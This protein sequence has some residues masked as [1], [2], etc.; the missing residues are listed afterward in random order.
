MQNTPD[1]KMRVARAV[2]AAGLALAAAGGIQ[3]VA[4][5]AVTRPS[6]LAYRGLGTW[7]DI[8]DAALWND[9]A[10]AVQ[11]MQADGIRTIY[12]QSSNFSHADIVFPPQFGQFIDAAHQAGMRVVAWYLPSLAHLKV[13]FRKSMAAIAY[14]STAESGVDSFALDIESR[15]VT[16]PT[17]RTAR[18]LDLSQRIRDAVGP[19]YPLGAITPNAVSLAKPTTFWPDFPYASLTR[20]YNVFLPMCYSGAVAAGG[21]AVH[22]YAANC[23][24]L[25][26]AGTGNPTVAIHQIGGVADNYDAA[27]IGGFVHAV[28]EYGLMGGSLYDFLTTKDPA[29][30]DLLRTI[31][32][33]P[34]ERPSLPIPIGSPDAV[35]NIPHGDRTHP[36]EVFYL[37]PGG[38]GAFNLTYQGFDLG[39]GEVT[40]W[41]N[42]ELV[43][44]IG[45]GPAGTWTRTRTI[46]IADEFL[47]D[48]APNSIGFTAAGDYPSW[49]TWG[50][51]GVTLSPSAA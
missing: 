51:R 3:A 46:P 8:Y 29:A 9:P 15:V 33:N 16:D 22:D 21:Q 36:K 19:G 48:D 11:S 37:A 31:P 18:L 4:K 6:L 41:V 25:V 14:R 1:T 35:G 24:G 39:S 26:R 23:A 43:K 40:L 34:R 42:W 30:W 28:R 13:D 44:T 47:L 7:V 49:S 17:V 5:D 2:L 20:Y 32:S 50:V 38:P 12:L 27:E 10:A 45:K